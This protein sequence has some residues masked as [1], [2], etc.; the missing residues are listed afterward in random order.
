MVRQLTNL[1]YR[2]SLHLAKSLVDYR[3]A[4][5]FRKYTTGYKIQYKDTAILPCNNRLTVL[6]SYFAMDSNV[7][8]T[9][10]TQ[11]GFCGKYRW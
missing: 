3:K 5:T 9:N 4:I 7:W 6:L 8:A 2:L 10:E 11:N 1:V